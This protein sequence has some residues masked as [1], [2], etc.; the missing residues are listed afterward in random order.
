MEYPSKLVEQ[1]VEEISKL[2]GIGKKT[3][4]RLALHMLKQP[5]AQTTNLSEALTNL[6]QNIKYC[7]TCHIIADTEECTCKTLSRDTSVIC[8]V[9]DTPDVLAIRNTGQY[10]GLFHV[11]G[12]RISPMDG[13]GPDNVKIDSLVDR[14]K[15][16]AAVKEV[17]LAL[18]STMEGDTTAFY[19]AKMLRDTPVKVSTIARGIPVGGELEYTDEITLAR[20]ISTRTLFSTEN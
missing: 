6:R 20:S 9:E 7:G 14:V 2:P 11:L 10:N 13:I 16:D 12:G 5:Q 1:A 3:A 17:V 8:V 18:S 15:S 4:L 19:I